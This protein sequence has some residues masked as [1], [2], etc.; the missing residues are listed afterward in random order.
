MGSSNTGHVC[1]EIAPGLL[2]I[3]A[4]EEFGKCVSDFS[5]LGFTMEANKLVIANGAIRFNL[6]EVE[7]FCVIHPLTFRQFQDLDAVGIEQRTWMIFF[8]HRQNKTGYSYP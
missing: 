6:A 1:L 3:I 8:S 2:K 4:Q 7:D 5:S